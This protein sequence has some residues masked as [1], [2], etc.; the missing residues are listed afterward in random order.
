MKKQSNIIFT[1][2]II[3]Y[4]CIGLGIDRYS[5][6]KSSQTESFLEGVARENEKY[7]PSHLLTIIFWPFYL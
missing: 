4:L 6:Y 3:S 5:D 7:S 2:I 1:V